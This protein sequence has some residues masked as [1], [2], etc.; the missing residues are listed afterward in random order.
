MKSEITVK[1]ME[2][3]RRYAKYDGKKI[4][5]VTFDYLALENDEEVIYLEVNPF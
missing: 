3:I 2:M 1:E 4:E 5:K